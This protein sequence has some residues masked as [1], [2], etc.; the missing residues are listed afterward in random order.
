MTPLCRLNLSN[1]HTGSSRELGSRWFRSA[2]ALTHPS[3]LKGAGLEERI[4]NC[5]QLVQFISRWGRCAVYQTHVCNQLQEIED[6]HLIW[7][8]GEDRRKP[9]MVPYL[10]CFDLKT[11]KRCKNNWAKKAMTASRTVYLQY[12]D[13]AE[14]II[15]PFYWLFISPGQV[16]WL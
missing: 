8:T 2:E 11:Y 4:G 1:N 7:I 14:S 3:A 9:A 6:W 12:Q 15:A 16:E 13:T 5:L 10:R